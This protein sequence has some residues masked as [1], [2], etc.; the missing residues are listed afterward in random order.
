MF[1]LLGFAILIT[2]V[3]A[4]PVPGFFLQKPE[5]DPFYAAPS[6]LDSLKNGEVYNQREVFDSILVEAIWAKVASCL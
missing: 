1:F 6:N 5:D 4:F 2:A 3:S